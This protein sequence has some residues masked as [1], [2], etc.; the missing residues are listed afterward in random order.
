MFFRKR[1]LREEG[2]ETVG[3]IVERRVSHS[4]V[5][6]EASYIHTVEFQGP[7]GP[8]RFEHKD[9]LLQEGQEVGVRFDP[10]DPSEAV[11][12]HIELTPDQI[13][14]RRQRLWGGVL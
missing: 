1:K 7:S 9:V 5:N 14:R 10:D 3:V 8:V 2:A 4:S 13:A 12:D 11:V 6:R